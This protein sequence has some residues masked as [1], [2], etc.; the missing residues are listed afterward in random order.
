[1]IRFRVDKIIVLVSV[2]SA[3][4]AIIQNVVGD[5]SKEVDEESKNEVRAD[6]KEA[7]EVAV[8]LS[9]PFTQISIERGMNLIGTEDFNWGALKFHCETIE[10]RFH[11]EIGMRVVFCLDADKSKHFSSDGFGA[12]VSGKFQSAAF[13]IDEAG[14]CFALHRFTAAAFHT[15]RAM[16]IAIR[17]AARCLSIPDPTK[18]SER[19]W[20]AILRV[21]KAERDARDKAGWTTASDKDFFED[22]YISLDAVRNAWRNATMHVEKEYNEEEADAVY[23]AVRTFMKKLASRMDEQGQPLA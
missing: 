6:L 10:K 14:K 11:D 17:A 15:M 12:D 22:I 19:N 23:R 9:L 21:L 18:P 2:L 16:E 3:I 13:D 8:T 4:Q 5:D 1:M 7:L 20:G